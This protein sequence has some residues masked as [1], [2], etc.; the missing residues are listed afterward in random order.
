MQLLCGLISVCSIGLNHF[1]KDM[2]VMSYTAYINNCSRFLTRGF[3]DAKT[4]VYIYS[5]GSVWEPSPI[6]A[7][8]FSLSF[9][10]F[11]DGL[12]KVIWVQIQTKHNELSFKLI[13]AS[14]TFHTLAVAQYSGSFHAC[15][16]FSWSQVWDMI[17][18]NYIIDIFCILVVAYVLYRNT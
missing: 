17:F 8:L 16:L 4:N 12:C 1:G 14:R 3:S 9:N 10:S 6:K 13:V 2:H 5:L 7:L 11:F 15:T 18:S